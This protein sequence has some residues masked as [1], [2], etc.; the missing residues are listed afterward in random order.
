MLF[1]ADFWYGR[2]DLV[3]QDLVRVLFL[4]VGGI[5]I[6]WMKNYILRFAAFRKFR[7][8]LFAVRD[9]MAI[10]DSGFSV[11]IS[12]MAFRN[13]FSTGSSGSILSLFPDLFDESGLYDSLT[14]CFSGAESVYRGHFNVSSGETRPFEVKCY[15]LAHGEDEHYAILDFRDIT[16]ETRTSTQQKTALDRQRVAIEILKLLNRKDYDISVIRKILELITGNTGIE[17]AG[18]KLKSGSEYRLYS[19]AGD[20]KLRRCIEGECTEADCEGGCFCLRRFP[21]RGGDEGL[22]TSPGIV[23][24]NNLD[25]YATA[26]NLKLCGHMTESSLR[27]FAVIPV[28][29]GREAIGFFI[30]ADRRR[31]FFSSELL[32]FY[33]GMAESIGIALDRVEFEEN[34]KKIIQE[35]EQ[36][37]REV[38]HRVKNN[39]QVITSLISLQAVRQSDESV[40]SILNECQNR[41]KT[42]ALVH[43]KL[44]SAGN[45]S[46]INFGNYINSLVSLLMNSYRIDPQLVKVDITAGDIVFGINVAIPLAQLINEILSNVFKHAFPG[47]RAGS[48]E[49]LL[50]RDAEK[51]GSMLFVRDT[52]AGLPE[53]VSYPSG[54]G[55]GFQLI[56]ALVRQI[57]GNIEYE[58][59]RGISIRV[60]F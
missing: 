20:E 17:A 26:K 45:Y 58:N 1:V 34:L 30:F 59:S 50:E 32:E 18:L 16:E 6:V 52:G 31:G 44:Y 8:I 42:M 27:S 24:S 43:E 40:R 29:S 39:M 15:P 60:T 3:S 2:S 46:S 28:C 13:T 7:D 19:S 21:D 5:F 37:I 22:L 55:L 56:E 38:H 41:V 25:E 4:L 47:G 12:N 14:V 36:L 9:P 33:E 51:G 23:W 53:G 10:V 35:K 11:V 48:V 54:G 57:R 49:I